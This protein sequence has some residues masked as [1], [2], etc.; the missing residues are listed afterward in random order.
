[1]VQGPQET[2]SMCLPIVERHKGPSVLNPYYR[3][4]R[5]KIIQSLTNDSQVSSGVVASGV[6]VS[7]VVV[8]GV[9][10]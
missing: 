4:F 7:G 5:K 9:V 8:S 2:P 6:V 10:A 1:M 3:T